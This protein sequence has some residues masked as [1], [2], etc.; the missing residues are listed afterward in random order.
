MDC[1]HPV[2]GVAC[3]RDVRPVPVS[4]VYPHSK[5]QPPYGL[6]AP[7]VMGSLLEVER[8]VPMGL[9]FVTSC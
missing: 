1:V 4:L 5:E 8:P 7:Y 6:C 2:Q 3:L 9:L